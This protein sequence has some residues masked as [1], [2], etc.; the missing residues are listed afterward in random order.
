MCKYI[1]TTQLKGTTEEHLE[2]LLNFVLTLLFSI[3]FVINCRQLSRS[4][5]VTI[6]MHFPVIFD[7]FLKLILLC[8]LLLMLAMVPLGLLMET[9]LILFTKILT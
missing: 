1:D 5:F 4:I 2:K 6:H 7:D 9:L 8:L 3:G